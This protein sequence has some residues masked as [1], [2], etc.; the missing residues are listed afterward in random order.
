MMKPDERTQEILDL[1]AEGWTREEIADRDGVGW[2]SIAQHMRRRGYCWSKEQQ[3]YI[4][5]TDEPEPPSAAAMQPSTQK[6]HKSS[7]CSMSNIPTSDKQQLN[8][9]F[10]PLK[11][12]AN[13]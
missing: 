11:K 12:W 9:G 4:P 13:T 8:K 3:T 7:E 6:Q 1:L 10:S 5:K 2:Q